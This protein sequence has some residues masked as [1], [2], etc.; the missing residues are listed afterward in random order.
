M[1]LKTRKMD[2]AQR[3]IY[4]IDAFNS[5]VNTDTVGTVWV[6]L[7]NNSNDNDNDNSNN[8]NNNNDNPY[9]DN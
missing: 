7:M 4:I 9:I 5:V 8:N 6:A 3:G 1:V 2:T